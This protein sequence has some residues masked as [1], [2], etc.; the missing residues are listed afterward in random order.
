MKGSRLSTGAVVMFMTEPWVIFI[1]VSLQIGVRW[2][3]CSFPYS[4]SWC[5]N[6]IVIP[7]KKHRNSSR[8]Q[9]SSRGGRLDQISSN[10]MSRTHLGSIG[11]DKIISPDLN[12]PLLLQFGVLWKG[13]EA[14]VTIGLR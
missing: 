10:K 3:L 12:S 1:R 9:S 5:W 13:V 11:D 14:Q 2:T 8:L 6:I 7:M 4:K